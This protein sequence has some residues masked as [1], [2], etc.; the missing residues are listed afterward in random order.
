MRPACTL[1]IIGGADLRRGGSQA[2][3]RLMASA[4]RGAAGGRELTLQRG[5]NAVETDLAKG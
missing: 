1:G 2:R 4:E 3:P 5:A